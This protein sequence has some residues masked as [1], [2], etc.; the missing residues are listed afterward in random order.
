MK[1]IAVIFGGVSPE[2]DVSIIT[3][4]IV[5]NSLDKTKF[6]PIP[7]FVTREGVWYTWEALT[8]LSFY[9]ALNYKI[10]TRVGL[11]V[12]DNYLYNERKGKRLFALAGA[13]NCMH[14]G[15][16]ENGTI[17]A[18]F[19]LCNVPFVGSGL[20]SASLSM[21]KALTKLAV[22][23][24]GVLSVEGDVVFRNE[25]FS[26]RQKTIAKIVE[27]LKLPLIV[28]PARTGSSIGISVAR[29]IKELE[30]SMVKAFTF[31][32]KIVVEKYIDGATEINCACYKTKNQI[33]VS[34]CE[35]PVT[36]HDI[37]T[38]EDKYLGSKTGLNTREFPARIDAKIS[39]EVKRITKTVYSA[40]EFSS[41][42][43]FDFL[44]KDNKVYLNEINSVPG[45]F[46]YYLFCDKI[47][48]LTDLLTDLIDESLA[49]YLS[50]RS[51]VLAFESS[52]LSYEGLSLKK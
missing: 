40:L 52:I 5:L 17:G 48:E 43:R 42:V 45:S 20:F 28:K 41:V 34:E 10:M 15:S 18:L 44:I 1:N 8:K 31:D 36:I 51:N 16:G 50:K 46:A 37:L 33:Y 47:S 9:K 19:D 30:S 3:G 32:D 14:G 38:V 21:D 29:N 35:R 7:V 24:L 12:G 26:A 6:S 49:N 22:K 2:H 27:G 4:L 23:G 11:R 13:I 39:D 25:Y